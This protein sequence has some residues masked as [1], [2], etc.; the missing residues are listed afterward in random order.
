MTVSKNFKRTAAL[1]IPQK[2]LEITCGSY[3]ESYDFSNKLS[4]KRF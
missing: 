2:F 1:P 3:Y 4:F